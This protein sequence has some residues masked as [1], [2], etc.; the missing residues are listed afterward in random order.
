M[1]RTADLVKWLCELLADADNLSGYTVEYGTA[2]LMNLVLRRAGKLRCEKPDVDVLGVLN[3][4][5]EHPS[6]QVRNF[7]NGALYSVLARP[8]LREAA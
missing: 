4:L 6:V 3:N 2:L 5:L 7:V 8:A 1:I